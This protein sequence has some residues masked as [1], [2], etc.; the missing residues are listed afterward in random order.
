MKNPRNTIKHIQKAKT[1]GQPLVCLTAYDVV[2]ARILDE[3]CD[4]LLVGDSLGMVLYGMEN[5]LS[6]SVRMM[7]D[8]GAAVVR[9]SKKALV[10]VDMPFGSYQQSPQKAFKNAAKIL[11]HSGAGAVKLEGGVEMADTIGFLSSR[12]IAVMGHVGLTPQSVN[13]LGGYG[14]QGKTEEEKQSILEDALA[15]EASGAFAVVLEGIT[16]SLA[17]TITSRLNIPTIGI[18]ASHKCDGQVLVSQD[19]LGLSGDHVPKFVKK[20]AQIDQN[21]ASAVSQFSNDVRQRQFP[22]DKHCFDIKDAENVSK[23]YS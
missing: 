13:T 1:L 12:G 10:V 18:G 11:Q 17:Q 4:L 2:M 6:V 14:Y 16:E 5:T 9:G 19:M 8:H 21:I 3:H 7:C 15:V 23:L 22:E 20:Y